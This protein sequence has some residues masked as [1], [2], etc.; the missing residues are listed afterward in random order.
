MDVVTNISISDGK[1]IS[2]YV[3]AYKFFA[4]LSRGKI[5]AKSS[6]ETNHD[7]ARHIKKRK[8]NSNQKQNIARK[9][10]ICLK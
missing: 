1:M 10:K 6:R 2:N 3:K 5:L 7:M 8:F 9:Y 4:R